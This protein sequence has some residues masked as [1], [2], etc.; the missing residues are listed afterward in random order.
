MKKIRKRLLALILACCLLAGAMPV[1]AAAVSFPDVPEGEWYSEYLDKVLQLPGIISGYPDGTFQPDAP[2]KRGEFL[3]MVICAAQLITSIYTADKSNDAVHWAGKYYTMAKEDNLLVSDVYSG[4]IMFPCTAE[5][6]D[7]PITRY[8]MATIISNITTN[9]LMEKAVVTTDAYANILDYASIPD[10]YITKVEQA[11]GKGILTGFEDTSFRG[12]GNL[13]RAQSVTVIER[14][15]WDNDR[16]MPDWAE[17]PQSNVSTA[18]RP[19][20]FV[21]FAE[22]LR[23][24]HVDAWGKID[25]EART[26]LFGD[27]NKTCFYS[28]AE[29]APFMQSVTVPI[30]AVDKGGNKYA[31]TAALTVHYLVADEVRYI[32]QE[33][34]DDP[35]QFP[36]YGWSIGG[37]RFTDTL[38]HSWGCAIDINALF[39]CECN[40]KSG[41]L[42]VTCG[43]GWW[44]IGHADGSFAGSLSGPSQYSIGKTEG[45]YGY[46]VVRAFAHYGWGWGGNGWS[47][48]KSF[49]YM[50]F[51]VLPSGG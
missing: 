23:D 13:T 49:D 12:D 40:T 47:N 34:F 6:L 2:V 46:S 39:N 31:T 10:S 20:G 5:A 30:W 8:E 17:Y 45:E 18:T 16:L 37:A 50:H 44:P 15:L 22:W 42:K 7:Q 43:Y 33:I 14:M 19:A 11:Y 4:G 9:S 27:P 41:Y 28:A 36:I 38:R 48:G 29:A 21:S 1:S 25:A 32:F 24:G 51:S 35:E 3:K 26:R